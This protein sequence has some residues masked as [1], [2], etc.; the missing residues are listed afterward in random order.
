MKAE[1][2]S[3]LVMCFLTAYGHIIIKYCSSSFVFS[4]NPLPMLK[5]FFQPLLFTGISA[6]LAAPLF[7]FYALKNM[8]LN[9]AYSFTAFNQILIPVLSINYF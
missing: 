6:V 5:Q 2:V 1:I 3:I 4:L 7:Y 8:K 9:T